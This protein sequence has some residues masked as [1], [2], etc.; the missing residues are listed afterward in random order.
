M[1]GLFGNRAKQGGRH[2]NLRPASPGQCLRELWGIDAGDLGA[3][4]KVIEGEVTHAHIINLTVLH[5][6]SGIVSVI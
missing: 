1:N 6:Q 5:V 4:G 2:P 3:R